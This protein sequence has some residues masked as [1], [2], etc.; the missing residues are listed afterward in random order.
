M[1]A[2]LQKLELLSSQAR[3]HSPGHLT[4]ADHRWS[5]VLDLWLFPCNRDQVSFMGR[6]IVLDLTGVRFLPS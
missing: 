2:D 4:A 1:Q 3:V 5:K 6:R